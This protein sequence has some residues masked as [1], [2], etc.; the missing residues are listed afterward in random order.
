[1]LHSFGK[2]QSAQ[3]KRRRKQKTLSERQE[4]SFLV[5]HFKPI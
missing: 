4:F 3:K 5:F 2:L 1:M